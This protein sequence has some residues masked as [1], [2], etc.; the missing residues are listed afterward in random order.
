MI[1]EKSGSPLAFSGAN[2]VCLITVPSWLKYVSFFVEILLVNV[3]CPWNVTGPANID[4]NWFD[5]PP[6]QL[7]YL[8]EPT[9]R[10]FR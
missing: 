2:K 7:S 9:Q 5:A 10:M 3:L 6:K 4:S 1:L 8:L